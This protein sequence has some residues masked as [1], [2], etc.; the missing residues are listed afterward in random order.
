M[1]TR[2]FYSVEICIP[3]EEI[4]DEAFEPLPNPTPRN[5][6]FKPK[7]LSIWRKLLAAFSA[8][9]ALGVF[10]YATSITDLS[11]IVNSSGISE[12]GQDQLFLYLILFA[13]LTMFL[14][15][16]GRRSAPS[17]EVQTPKKQRNLS[18]RTIAAA[19]AILLFIPLTIFAGIYYLDDRHYNMVAVAVL[20][21]CMTP[22]V[23]V[24]EGRKPK[25]RELVTIALLCAS[26][27]REE[28]FS[29]CFRNLSLCCD[30]WVHY[31][32]CHSVHVFE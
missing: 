1:K 11:K 24:F 14:I 25:A 13:A 20:L 2:R 18:K 16:I 31:E 10:L 32:P 4:S 8:L 15:A 9:I 30:I 21:E 5:V 26:V 12:E 29:L 27:L 7:P 3:K 19:V 17:L 28:V 22:F 23:L 6:N